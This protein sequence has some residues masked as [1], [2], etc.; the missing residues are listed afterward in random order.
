MEMKPVLA[1]VQ[2]RGRGRS[3]LFRLQSAHI[4]LCSS[5]SKALMVWE[6]WAAWPGVG[7]RDMIAAT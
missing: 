1:Q 6:F 7:R 2:R 4:L 5:F 3:R